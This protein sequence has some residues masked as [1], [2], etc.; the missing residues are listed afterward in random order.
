MGMCK[1]ISS[2]KNLKHN[3]L[4]SLNGIR[5]RD[6]L[7]SM[8]I[9]GG[10]DTAIQLCL[11]LHFGIRSVP[12]LVPLKFCLYKLLVRQRVFTEMKALSRVIILY[13]HH[14]RPNTTAYPPGCIRLWMLPLWIHPP[15]TPLLD[16]P[17]LDASPATRR[18]T[19]NR[20]SVRIRQEFILSIIVCVLF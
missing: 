2:S 9:C 15:N 16:A 17:P 1:E 4:Q 18:Q 10:F 3:G 8:I 13:L 5:Y 6:K 20:R 19:V 12:V 7:A 14:Y 11:Y